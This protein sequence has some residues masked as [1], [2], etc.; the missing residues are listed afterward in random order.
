[1]TYI[2]GID[3]STRAVH[4]A[5]VPLHEPAIL[6]RSIQLTQ[7][8]I[9]QPKRSQHVDPAERAIRGGQAARTCLH[10]LHAR[11]LEIHSC[12]V[13]HPGGRYVHPTLYAAFGAVCSALD[14]YPVASRFAA[15]WRKA[16]GCEGQAINAKDRGQERVLDL[17]APM[18][19]RAEVAAYLLSLTADLYDAIG[20]ALAHRNAV[21]ASEE[22]A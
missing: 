16:I 7:A 1:M 9:E 12:A 15:E 10:T 18:P 2:L 8:D 13:E 21:Q 4:A 17:V 6:G 3:L 19:Y 11:G 5:A 22:A 20:I 14:E